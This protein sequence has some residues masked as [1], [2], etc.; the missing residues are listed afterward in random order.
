MFVSFSR[1]FQAAARLRARAVLQGGVASNDLGL[2]GRSLRV[3]LAW[4]CIPPL[5]PSQR[6]L[7]NPNC[8]LLHVFTTLSSDFTATRHKHKRRAPQCVTC[9]NKVRAF[10]AK[11]RFCARPAP[12]NDPQGRDCIDGVP[13]GASTC[14][15]AW[16]AWAECSEGAG[17]RKEQARQPTPASPTILPTT[18]QQNIFRRINKRLQPRQFAS[19]VAQLPHRTVGFLE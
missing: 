2:W 13:R 7:T 18:P 8:R 12:R 5:A 10:R 19:L 17:G 16:G 15:C 3:R 14:V 6:P 9:A 11:R 4:R 1:A